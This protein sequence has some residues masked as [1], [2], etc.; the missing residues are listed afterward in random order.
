VIPASRHFRMKCST[1]SQ[2]LSLRRL[3]FARW[4]GSTPS[5]VAPEFDGPPL[6]TFPSRLTSAALKP[7][8]ARVE[9][10]LSIRAVE[11]S[12]RIAQGES[13][14]TRMG[15]PAWSTKYRPFR[16]TLFTNRFRGTDRPA[17]AVAC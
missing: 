6:A 16:L 17:V 8:L 1:R 13:P 4:N 15:R 3:G 11:A 7:C 12:T 9:T 2:F 14:S 5:Y 10:Y